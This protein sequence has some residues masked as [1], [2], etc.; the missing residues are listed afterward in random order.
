[1]QRRGDREIDRA[2]Y[3]NRDNERKQVEDH[4]RRCATA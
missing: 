4:Q 2:E 3:W 1:L